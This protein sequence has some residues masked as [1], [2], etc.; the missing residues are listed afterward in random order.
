MSLGKRLDT[1]GET[2]ADSSA[3]RWVS[4][5]HH[6]N[7][8]IVVYGCGSV[9]FGANTVKAHLVTGW[10]QSALK[11]GL[12]HTWHPQMSPSCERCVHINHLQSSSLQQHIQLVGKTA[13]EWI[14]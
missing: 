2:C 10:C 7:S 13:Q 9:S 11:V 14:C 4:D 5:K 8:T 12:L 3:A 1:N 6:C